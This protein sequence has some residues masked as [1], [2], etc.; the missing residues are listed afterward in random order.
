MHALCITYSYNNN[1]GLSSDRNPCVRSNNYSSSYAVDTHRRSVGNLV[2]IRA[3]RLKLQSK[4]Y[5]LLHIIITT[6]CIQQS[7]LIIIIALP[8]CKNPKF[9]HCTINSD[10]MH[11]YT[12]NSAHIQSCTSDFVYMLNNYCNFL[13][14][15][16]YCS[17]IIHL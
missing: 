13:T 14:L 2:V 3:L 12:L 7:S 5:L 4:L 8:L 10:V 1:Y 6:A 15:L 17:I 9:S 11:S 16:H